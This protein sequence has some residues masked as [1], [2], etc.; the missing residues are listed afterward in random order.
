MRTSIKGIMFCPKKRN[1]LVVKCSIYVGV[2]NT[3]ELALKALNKFMESLNVMREEKSE[4]KNIFKQY[5]R[6]T[7]V[8]STLPS[9]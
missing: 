1:Y 5:Y 9:V 6:E 4:F 7:L 8:Q 3:F 2:F